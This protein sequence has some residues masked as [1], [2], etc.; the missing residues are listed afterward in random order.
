MYFVSYL[1]PEWA[2]GQWS[3]HIFAQA[4]T[5]PNMCKTQCALVLG[6]SWNNRDTVCPLFHWETAVVTDES[7]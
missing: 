2:E 7:R 1:L 4:S 5:C 3:L 6:Q